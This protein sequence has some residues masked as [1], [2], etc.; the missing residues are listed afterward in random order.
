MSLIKFKNISKSFIGENGEIN[1]VFN[2]L[3]FSI[4]GPEFY[5]I[6]GPNGSGKSSILNMIAGIIKPDS[7]EIEYRFKAAEPSIG[8]IWQDYRSSLLPWLNVGDNIT[9]PL[10]I[11]G[12]PRETRIEKAE[13]LVSGFNTDF[14]IKRKTYELSGGQLQIVNILR[15]MVISPDVL[16]LDEPF[17]A[18]DQFNRWSLGF[19]FEK[20]W[21]DIKIPIV[22]ISHDVDE[23]VLLGDKIW[24]LNKD[25]YIEKTIINDSPRPRNIDMLSSERHN[26]CRNEVIQFLFEQ[27]ALKNGGAE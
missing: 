18:L 19:Q 6:V 2:S 17:S 26:T 22:F 25:G 23:A 15:S 12:V 3:S 1:Q 24:L 27:G 4:D 16:L 21:L 7:G 14:D 9:F 13:K 20:I 5:T 10:K 11:Q 8:Y